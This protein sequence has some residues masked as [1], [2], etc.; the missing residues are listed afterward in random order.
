[1]GSFPHIQIVVGWDVQGWMS[2]KQAVAVLSKRGQEL[3][4]LA[5]REGFKFTPHRKL[6]FQSLLGP[7]VEGTLDDAGFEQADL[8]IAI[9]APLAFSS[10]FRDLVCGTAASCQAP[11]SE[12]QNP[13]AYRE[14]ERWV[15]QNFSKKPLSATFDKLGNNASLAITVARSLNK[16]GFT[17]VPQDGPAG[18]KSIIEVY[19]GLAKIGLKTIDPAIPPLARMIPAKIERGSDIY[20]A[21]ICALLGAVQLGWGNEIGVPGLMQPVEGFD[22]TEGWIYCLPPKYVRSFQRVDNL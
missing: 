22:S 11:E 16:E 19:P 6:D 9:D 14:C 20:D 1:M 12:I 18:P 21:A 3:E 5:F 17:L 13:L 7:E 4:W 2:K 8:L 15:H 10:S